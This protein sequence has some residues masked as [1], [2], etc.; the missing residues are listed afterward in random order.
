LQQEP[1]KPDGAVS[2][3]SNRQQI[4]PSKSTVIVPRRGFVPGVLDEDASGL[5]DHGGMIQA[6][7]EPTD[8]QLGVDAFQ[9]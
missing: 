8:E 5:P 4:I 7:V 9:M 3:I 2:L 1:A 6:N